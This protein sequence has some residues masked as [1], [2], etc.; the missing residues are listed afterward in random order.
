MAEKSIDLAQL[1]GTVATNLLANQSELN[2][3][4]TQNNNHGDNIT[5]AFQIITQAVQASS[6]APVST[7]LSNASAA[8]QQQV[9]TGSGQ[10][11]AQGLAQAA[12]QLQGQQSLTPDNMMTLVTSLLGGGSS[13]S[14]QSAQGQ[15]G[16][17]LGGL[18]GGLMGGGESTASAQPAQAQSGD[19]LGGLLGSLMGGASANGGSNPQGLDM[20]DLINAGLGY[21]Q[22]KGRGED[23]LQAIVDGII[24][25]SPL[26]SSPARARSAQIVAGTILQQVRKMVPPAN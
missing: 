26:G 5:Q 1:F 25:A 17:L 14:V 9:S 12:N 22:A 8:L 2:N 13:N 11:Y 23:D 20:G 21:M 16:D 6:N 3:A 7:Q 10:Y 18:L 15:S 4:D 24:S 19:M